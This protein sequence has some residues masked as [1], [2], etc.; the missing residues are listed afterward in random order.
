MKKNIHISVLL[1]LLIT[2]SSCY[3]GRKPGQRNNDRDFTVQVFSC[4][5]EFRTWNTTDEVDAEFNGNGSFEFFDSKDK[6]VRVAGNVVVTNKKPRNFHDSE[7]RYFIE[8]IMC[9]SIVCSWESIGN[10]EQ[11]R[12]GYFE[13]FD[14]NKNEIQVCGTVMITEM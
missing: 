9:D 11:S 4:S 5:G 12:D 8:M 13:F 7:V 10:V 1:I 14:T 6:Y 3:D 2:L